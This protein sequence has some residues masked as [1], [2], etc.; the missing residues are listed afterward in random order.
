MPHALASTNEPEWLTLGL[1]HAAPV[2]QLQRVHQLADRILPAYAVS[3]GQIHLAGCTLEDV[4]VLRF[5]E[6]G[7]ADVREW[8]R[9]PATD[10]FCPVSTELAK[11]LGLGSLEATQPPKSISVGMVSTWIDA[12]TALDAKVAGS[13]PTAAIA[14]KPTQMIWCKYARG[15]VQFTIGE[16][17]VEQSFCQWAHRLEAPDYH[18]AVTGTK[19]YNL[20]ATSDGRVIAEAEIA[21]CEISGKRLPQAELIYCT[22]TGQRVARELAVRCPISD[23]FLLPDQRE[24][25]RA[26]RQWV[27]PLRMDG[28]TCHVCRSL[29]RVDRSDARV[30]RALALYPSLAH[31]RS[32]RLG[33]SSE[34][35]V[36]KASKGW[37]Q[38]LL[39]FDQKTDLLRCAAGK[40]RLGRSWLP[41][42]DQQVK[43]SL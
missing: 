38:R 30:L 25:C 6:V 22:V 20:A 28:E 32:L 4:P 23:A 34:V 31:W 16:Q 3:G 33:F 24:C 5:G 41:I 15:K 11:V 43:Q 9:M 2:G 1:E 27:S 42:D 10:E 14:G 39:V 19:T 17:V 26:C 29:K 12:V 13:G 7:S 37:Q 40:S 35:M 18:C 36:L 21:R 8:I